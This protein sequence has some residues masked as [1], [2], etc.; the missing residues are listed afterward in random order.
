[1][2]NIPSHF[3]VSWTAPVSTVSIDNFKVEISSYGDSYV[4]SVIIKETTYTCELH[5]I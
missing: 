2:I 5:F 3:Q 4:E 1:M